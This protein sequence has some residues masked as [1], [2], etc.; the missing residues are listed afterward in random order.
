MAQAVTAVSSAA[1]TRQLEPAQNSLRERA[2]CA[3]VGSVLADRGLS[4]FGCPEGYLRVPRGGKLPASGLPGRAL[5][6]PGDGAE[7]VALCVGEYRPAS[8]R[9]VHLPGRAAGDQPAAI[10]ARVHSHVEVGHGRAPA[11]G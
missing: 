3:D 7:Q 5:T 8:A 2:F 10:L 1:S 9:I 4:I 11:A 6:R